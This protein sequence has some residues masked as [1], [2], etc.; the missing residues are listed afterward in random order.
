M[1]ELSLASRMAALKAKSKAIRE[2]QEQEK[3]VI[4]EATNRTPLWVFLRFVVAMDNS[5]KYD[6]NLN[7]TELLEL[8]KYLRPLSIPDYSHIKGEIPMLLAGKEL[9]NITTMITSDD[10]QVDKSNPRGGIERWSGRFRD[11]FF[12]LQREVVPLLYRESQE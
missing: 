8:Y 9:S 12:C 2:T 10:E 4:S 3:I 6:P 1:S 7:C 5:R 11:V